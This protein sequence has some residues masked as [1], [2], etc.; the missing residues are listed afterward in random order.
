MTDIGRIEGT[1]TFSK[2]A[3]A[4][5]PDGPQVRVI[6]EYE[7]SKTTY[8]APLNSVYIGGMKLDLIHDEFW[9]RP[10]EGNYLWVESTGDELFITEGKPD[11]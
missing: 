11:E 2:V 6:G 1:A 5:A 3:V 9:L 7:D 8:E 10:D 4:P